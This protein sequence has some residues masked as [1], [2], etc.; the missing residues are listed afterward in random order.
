MHHT[1]I[2]LISLKIQSQVSLVSSVNIVILYIVPCC[3]ALQS[4][5]GLR[6]F[7]GVLYDHT[8]KCNPRLVPTYATSCLDCDSYQELL[9]SLTNISDCYHTGGPQSECSTDEEN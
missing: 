5:S 7:V 6:S 1:H 2:F 8:L 4:H 3:T 9:T